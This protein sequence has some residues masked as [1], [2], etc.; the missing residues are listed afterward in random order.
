M[1]IIALQYHPSSI[2]GIDLDNGLIQKAGQQLRLVNSLH[3][4]KG[5]DNTMDISMRFHYFPRALASIHGV[6]PMT[7]PP[8]YKSNVFPYNVKF[9]TNNWMEMDLIGHKHYYDTILA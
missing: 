3:N 1:Y 9:E 6:I 5:D 4:P 7:M 8:N 2:L